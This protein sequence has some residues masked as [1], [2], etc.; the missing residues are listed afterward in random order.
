MIGLRATGSAPVTIRQ[1]ERHTI[2][3]SKNYTGPCHGR[4]LKSRGADVI[5]VEDPQEPDQSRELGAD[6]ALSSL[7][8]TPNNDGSVPWCYSEIA[9]Q[10]SMVM[11]MP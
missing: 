10:P 11:L 4:P 5:K 7:W 6:S 2:D 9:V 3:C 8:S 1:A